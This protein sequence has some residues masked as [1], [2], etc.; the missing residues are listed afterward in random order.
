MTPLLVVV[1]VAIGLVIGL[2]VGGLGGGGG[3]L[4]VPAL[5]YLLDQTPQA[6][7]TASL[8]IV[9]IS[10]VIGVVTRARG[11][12]VRWAAG[13]TL[14]AI[15]AVT[16]V[17]GSVLSRHLDRHVLLLAF[18]GIVL[19]AAVLMLRKPAPA[20]PPQPD[21][22]HAPP[23]SDPPASDPSAGAPIAGKVAGRV[24]TLPRESAVPVVRWRAA[25]IVL[26]GSVVG[27]ATGLFGVGGGFLVVPA[28]VLLLGWEMPAAVAT[29]L[30]VIVINCVASLGAR[31]ATE[32]FDWRIIVPVTAA[33]VV[34]TL[35]GKMSADRLS[36]TVLTRAFAVLLLLVA[37]Y[38][39]TTSIIALA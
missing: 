16:A 34:G 14:G 21:P 27:F 2:A 38:T 1:A 18:A 24:V 7:A 30:L 12:Q 5:V 3:V 35:I 11:G 4:T 10:A 20:S 6:A 9:G 13:A 8:V 17:A 22:W 37:G 23:A 25:T 26:A 36:S 39:A 19:L 15:G 32:A 29:S 31:V 28:L 33:A